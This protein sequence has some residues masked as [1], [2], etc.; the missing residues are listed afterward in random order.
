MF[1]MMGREPGRMA[2]L[3]PGAQPYPPAPSAA[4]PARFPRR[5]ARPGALRGCRGSAP[6]SWWG[7]R[8]RPRVSGPSPHTGRRPA[9][10]GRAARLR[11]RCGRRGSA[12]CR[13]QSGRSHSKT[14]GRR[15]NGRRRARPHGPIRARERRWH[16][17]SGS[18]P[19]PTAPETPRPARRAGAGPAPSWGPGAVVRR[20]CSTSLPSLQMAKPTS[21]RARAWRRTASTQWASSVASLFK[22]LRRAGVLKNSSLHL[23]AWCPWR[24]R[25][26]RSSPLRASRQMGVIYAS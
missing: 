8:S 10:C 23:D 19:R 14:A 16:P 9:A 4:R 6:R 25:R 15:A 3:P 26:G 21:G 7:A 20:H 17:W 1:L 2:V 24:G 11:T 5:G 22:N 12:P 13:A 18:R